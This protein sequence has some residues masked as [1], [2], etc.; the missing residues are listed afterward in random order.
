MIEIGSTMY[1]GPDE[2]VFL[3]TP[4]TEADLCKG[5]VRMGSNAVSFDRI[6]QI[7]STFYTSY[8]YHYFLTSHFLLQFPLHGGISEVVLSLQNTFSP[9]F[10]AD[11]KYSSHLYFDEVFC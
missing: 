5:F 8:D 7:H 10:P 6:P 1:Q 11:W 2:R 9:A 4:L 3:F